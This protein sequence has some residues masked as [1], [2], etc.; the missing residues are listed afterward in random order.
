MKPTWFRKAAIVAL[1]VLGALVAIIPSTV[2]L[3]AAFAAGQ[4]KD[5]MVFVLLLGVIGMITAFALWV[6]GGPIV[7]PIEPE[8]TSASRP[9]SHA[10]PRARTDWLLISLATVVAALLL[11]GMLARS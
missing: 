9:P 8:S 4:Q 7:T 5:V 6:T 2:I 10:R 11:I 1:G 3:C